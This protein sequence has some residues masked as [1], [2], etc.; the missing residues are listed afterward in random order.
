[1]NIRHSSHKAG[2]SEHVQGRPRQVHFVPFQACPL[3]QTALE[4][5][6]LA[7]PRPQIQSK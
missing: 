3:S 1:M 6:V 4:T 2:T 5:G 7:N